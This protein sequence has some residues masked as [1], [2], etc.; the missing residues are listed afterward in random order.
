MFAH[1]SS[2]AVAAT[3]WLLA[4]FSVATWVLILAKAMQ[5]IRSAGGNRRYATRSARRP[6]CSRPR[7]YPTTAARIARSPRSAS[8]CCVMPP[9]ADSGS[10]E[11]AFDRHELL[12]E[13]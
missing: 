9:P 4:A 7:I 1:S 13:T 6:V 3:L 11:H 5:F 2:I 8:A 10:D 12:E